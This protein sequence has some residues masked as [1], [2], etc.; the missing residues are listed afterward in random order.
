MAYFSSVLF[1]NNLIILISLAFGE[2]F[3]PIPESNGQLNAKYNHYKNEHDNLFFIF[4][5]FRHGARSPI[6]LKKKNKDM[7]GGEWHS[8]GELT[9]FGRRQHYQIGLKMR[10]RYSNFISE[11]YDPK[12]LK[13]YATNFDRTINSVQSQLLGLYSNI[14]YNDYNFSDFNNKNLFYNNNNIE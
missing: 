7:L 12:E 14:S 11:K 2:K 5:N 3:N 13:I 9:Y 8:K 4:L 6:Y 1:I 10:E